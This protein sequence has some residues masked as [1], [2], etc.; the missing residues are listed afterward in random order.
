LVNI[1]TYQSTARQAKQNCQISPVD[2]KPYL[3]NH[4]A[5]KKKKLANISK[6]ICALW[7][8]VNGENP[9]VCTV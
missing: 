5:E 7:R 4:N 6:L 3:L 9:A 8:S 2:F 1:G